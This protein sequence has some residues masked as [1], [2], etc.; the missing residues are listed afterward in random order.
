[1]PGVA[2]VEAPLRP[3][4]PHRRLLAATLC[5]VRT[6]WSICAACRE[7]ARCRRV[8]AQMSER[9]LADIGLSRSE[10]VAEVEKPLWHV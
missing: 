7:R 1:M 9:E 5:T 4:R 2:S 10:I 3:A 6:V 8:L